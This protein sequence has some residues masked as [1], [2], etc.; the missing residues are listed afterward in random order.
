MKVM[1]FDKSVDEPLES[2]QAHFTRITS[3]CSTIEE[4]S[5]VARGYSTANTKK[6]DLIFSSFSIS[7]NFSGRLRRNG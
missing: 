3:I 6:L 5:F 7:V 4:G 1:F 2:G